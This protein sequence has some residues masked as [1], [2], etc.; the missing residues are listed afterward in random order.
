MKPR[1]K[2]IGR[3]MLMTGIIA[4]GTDGLTESENIFIIALQIGNDGNHGIHLITMLLG[5]HAVPN[6]KSSG[7]I[8][9]GI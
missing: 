8:P 5:K 2:R 9:A 7:I 3:F 6:A 1:R 4:D